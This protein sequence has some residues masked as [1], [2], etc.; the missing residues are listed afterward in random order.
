MHR[1]K[2]KLEALNRLSIEAFKNVAKRPLV[3][4]LDNVRSM[5]NVG[6]VLRTA[7][8]FAVAKVYLCGISPRPPH[9]E[10]RKTAIGAEDSVDWEGRSDAIS[11]CQELKE[12]GYQLLVLEQAEGSVAL[13]DF[14]PDPASPKALV[15][16]H[17]VD[18]V[19]QTIVDMADVVLEIP[20]YG[21]KHSLNVS[22]SAGIVIHALATGSE[23]RGTGSKD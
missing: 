10:I 20:Q 16:G 21:T 5:H 4:I 15:L 12:A 3:V 22:V 13:E 1:P 14:A 7:D 17:E 18:G 2:K 11:L 23:H 8:A 9:R 6:S 19:R